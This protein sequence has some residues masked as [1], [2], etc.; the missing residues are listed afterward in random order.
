MKIQPCGIPG[1]YEISL[2]PRTDHRGYFMRTYDRSI[3]TD[4]GLDRTWVQENESF[5]RSK[6]TIRGLHLQL[7][8]FAETKLIRVTKGA[9]FDVFADLR[10]GSPTF[11]QWGAV[12]LSA[13]NHKMV[14]IPRGFAHGY[15]TLT[16]ECEIVYKVDNYYAPAYESGVVWNDETLRIDWPVAAPILSSKDSHLPS[17]R[18]FVGMNEDSESKG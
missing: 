18:M 1:V 10:T 15:C 4:H 14:Y 8:P 3:W 5:S 16:D 13:D 9:I 2:I 6:G 17:L 12:E 7:P 11:G